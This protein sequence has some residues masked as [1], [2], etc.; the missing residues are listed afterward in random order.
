MTYR[1]SWYVRDVAGVE[2]ARSIGCNT[3][4]VP[5]I[6]SDAEMDAVLDALQPGEHAVIAFGDGGVSPDYAQSIAMV[7]RVK[8]R[9]DAALTFDEA[10]Y[11]HLIPLSEQRR[12]YQG[13]KAIKPSLVVLVGYYAY[14]EGVP[15]AQFVSPTPGDVCDGVVLDPYP[16][17]QGETLETSTAHFLATLAAIRACFSA[18]MPFVPLVQAAWESVPRDG[19]LGPITPEQMMLVYAALRDAG[20]LTAAASNGAAAI[21]FYGAGETAP[22]EDQKAKTNTEIAA[23]IA[24]VCARHQSLY[25]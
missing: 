24:A 6:L 23:G 18:S 17:H 4:I 14:F 8:D 21:G 20:L 2:L 15:N 10:N 16:M 25:P 1:L 9:I 22:D 13:V 19:A 11:P 7:A 5:G 3:V 12:Y